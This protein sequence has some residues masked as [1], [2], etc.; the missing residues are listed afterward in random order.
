MC[1]GVFFGCVSMYRMHEV[2]VEARRGQQLP[3]KCSYRWPL[4]ELQMVTVGS[5]APEPVGLG[6]LGKQASQARKEHSRLLPSPR[7]A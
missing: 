6:W 3:L 7:S 2:P 1:V 5:G 4:W